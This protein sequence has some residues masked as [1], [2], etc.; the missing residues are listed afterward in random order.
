MEVKGWLSD[1]GGL[2]CTPTFG[3]PRFVGR[4]GLSFI[5]SR[6]FGSP[7]LMGQSG[8]SFIRSR[9]FGS[10]HLVG[11]LGLSVTRTMVGLSVSHPL[12]GL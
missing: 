12:G 10:P 11:Q 6:V 7:H 5:R 1:L 9:V 2:S 3:S 8:L 4:L